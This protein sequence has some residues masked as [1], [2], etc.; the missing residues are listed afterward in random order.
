MRLIISSTGLQDEEPWKVVCLSARLSL[1]SFL[2]RFSS[3][4]VC[5]VVSIVRV[6][7]AALARTQGQHTSNYRY[8]TDKDKRKSVVRVSVPRDPI[9]KL[10]EKGA[11]K[12]NSAN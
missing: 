12:Y 2:I 4:R 7:W 3:P 11:A 8:R 10:T 6:Q 5:R 9:S 1:S